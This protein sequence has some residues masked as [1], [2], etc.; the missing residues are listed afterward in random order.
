MFIERISFQEEGIMK[1]LL[2]FLLLYPTTGWSKAQCPAGLTQQ[3]C[4]DQDPRGATLTSC[5]NS[6]GTCTGGYYA[7]CFKCT[8]AAH[9]TSQDAA[10]CSTGCMRCTSMT[11]CTRCEVGY[12]MNS[13]ECFKCPAN[14]YCDG[15]TYECNDGYEYNSSSKSCVKSTKSSY[16]IYYR[17][18][19]WTSNTQK[20]S[21][22]VQASSLSEAASAIQ[23]DWAPKYA[24]CSGDSSANAVACS[25]DTKNNVR[26]FWIGANCT[27]YARSNPGVCYKAGTYYSA[28]DTTTS[29]ANDCNTAYEKCPAGCAACSINSGIECTQCLSGYYK[30]NGSCVSS[31][32]SGYTPENGSCVKEENP[33]PMSG[34]CPSPL[35]KSADGC[36]CVK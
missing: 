15:Y 5:D 18:A 1:I 16:D 24:T 34:N 11:H 3:Q 12:Y 20:N 32:P 35:K 14:A 29:P 7:G 26:Y 36:C 9:D 27:T 33:V 2:F 25:C 4:C 23:T 21:T 13:Y 28:Y 31:C 10:S 30:Y 22:P 6:C 17:D 19:V 8:G